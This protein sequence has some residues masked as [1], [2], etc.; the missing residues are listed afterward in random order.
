M[1]VG[2]VVRFVMASRIG[3]GSLELRRTPGGYLEH[4]LCI[5]TRTCEYAGNNRKSLAGLYAGRH[6]LVEL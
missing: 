5:D 4:I 3:F 2:A 1:K 6:F